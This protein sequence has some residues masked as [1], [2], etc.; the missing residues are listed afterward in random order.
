MDTKVNYVVVGIF[1][2]GLTLASVFATV[3]IAGGHHSK[4]YNRFLTFVN[5]PVDGLSEK[6][7]VKFNGVDV[8][9]VDKISLNPAD[10]QEVR[11]E[12]NIIDGTP[13]NQN[14]VAT[15]RSSALTGFTYLGLHALKKT[16]PALVVPENENLPII[17]YSSSL[18]KKLDTI[19]QDVSKNVGRVTTALSELLGEQ[20]QRL[21]RQILTN[22]R[23]VTGT[24]GTNTRELDSILNST[25]KMMKNSAQAS[26]QFDQ[27]I[28]SLQKTLASAKKATDNFSAMSK[29][30]R[31]TF[32][33]S[34]R[35]VKDIS[36]Q[37]LPSVYASIESLKHTLTNIENITGQLKNN[38]SMLV[39]GRNP[40][41]PGP[42]E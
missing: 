2:I 42:G 4:H 33:S 37:L 13:I 36:E 28:Q 6:S 24:L 39:R 15:I 10:P 14:T 27:S 11:L 17:P 3:W 20:N 1:V 30:A 5:E 9:Y 26:K 34:N 23:D 12:V 31:N 25:D 19:A 35:T 16:G 22:V 29:E 32:S 41:P 40:S 38:P 7:T 18:F 21:V 8:G